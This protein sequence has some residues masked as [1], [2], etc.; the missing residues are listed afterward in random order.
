MGMN[1]RHFEGEHGFRFNFFA[2]AALIFG[3]GVASTPIAASAVATKPLP[4]EVRAYFDNARQEC[5]E[6]GDRLH[7]T[8]ESGF[9]ETADFNGDG[10]PDYI[11]HM[12]E[13]VCPSLGYSEYC[14]SAGCQIAILVSQGD[15]LRE[16]GGNN[17]Q[18][19]AITKP[20]GGKQSL[21]FAAHGSFCGHKSG[22]DTCYGTMSWTPKG[23]KTT[24]TAAEPAALKAALNAPPAADSRP[25]K[26]PKYDWKFVGPA[27]GKKGASI[28]MSDGTPDRVK[29]VVACAERT[30]VLVVS[31]PAGTDA[32]PSGMP[33]MIELGDAGPNGTHADVILQQV[34]DKSAYIGQL[35]SAALAIMQ[36]AGS[37]DYALVSAAWTVAS[38]DYWIDMPP[39]PLA[40]FDETSKAVLKACAARLR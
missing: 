9:A 5:R 14:G 13:L 34:Q 12:S 38:R 26:N 18:A 19:F 10:K 8:S 22:A 27:A 33:V 28:T 24:Y 32:P 35:P 3:A 21:V 7:V 39:L 16:A 2:F 40:H 4:P 1:R 29:V 6:A 30:P 17:Y 11:V 37:Q 25:D 23:F 36:T 31:F 15:R 20:V